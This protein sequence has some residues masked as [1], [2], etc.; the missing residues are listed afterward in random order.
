MSGPNA[1]LEI[2]NEPPDDEVGGVVVRRRSLEDTEMDITPMIDCTFLLLIFFLLT[3]KADEGAAI[4]LPPAKYGIPVPTKNA[5][6]LTILKGDGDRPAKVFEGN[7][8]SEAALVDSRDLKAMED[9][10]AGYVEK[11]ATR[12]RKTYVLI[13]AAADVKHRDVARV[14]RAASR[15]GEIEQLHVAVLEVQ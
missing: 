2:G 1:A 5:V 7:T 10:V 9:E 14:A 15:V 4:P 8:T 13:K 3:F 12:S 6:V 11:E